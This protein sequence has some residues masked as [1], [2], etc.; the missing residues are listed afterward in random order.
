MVRRQ[1]S[2]LRYRRSARRDL[3][4]WALLL[5]GA[6]FVFAAY[7]VDPLANCDEAGNCAPWVVP[8]AGI[9]GWA[10]VAMGLGQLYANPRRGYAIDSGNGDLTWWKNR[11]GRHEGDGGRI[12][13]SRIA[14]IHL[15]LRDER[16]T[17]SLYDWDGER[18]AF[19][20]E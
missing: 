4:S 5:V 19:F 17:V 1:Q 11:T 12:H 13:P 10:A 20:D 3:T 16:D 18:L 14:R 2:V 7:T 15:D 9:M 8:V 6:L